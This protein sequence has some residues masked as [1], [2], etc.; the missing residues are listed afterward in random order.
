MKKVTR[1]VRN[2]CHKR[3]SP[4]ARTLAA[5]GR[6]RFVLP[7]LPV[8]VVILSLALSACASEG[9]VAA[10]VTPIGRVKSPEGEMVIGSGGPGQTTMRIKQKLVDIQRGVAPDPHGWV[11][12]ID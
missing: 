9:A 11:Q 5:A 2:R 1:A 3:R 8:A 6:L 12:R 7:R 10:V 4:P